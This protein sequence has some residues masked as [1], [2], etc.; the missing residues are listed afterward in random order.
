MSLDQIRLI[1]IAAIQKQID[2]L[3]GSRNELDKV[4]GE[5]EELKKKYMATTE[6]AQIV[7]KTEI[8]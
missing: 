4:I 8:I 7:Y 3:T 1:I 6:A 5:L 2:D